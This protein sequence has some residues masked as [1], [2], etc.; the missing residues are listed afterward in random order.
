MNPPNMKVLVAPDK[1]K[2]SLDAPAAARAL[3][4]GMRQHRPDISFVE[5]PV[6]DGGD[7]FLNA[8]DGYG[9]R[10]QSVAV[11]GPLREQVIAEFGV[12]GNSAVVEMATSSGLKTVAGRVLNPMAAT[13]Y[14]VGELL[15]AARESGATKIVVGVGGSATTDGGAGMLV[16]LGARLLDADG[17]VLPDCGPAELR[18]VARVDL[19]GLR[20]DLASVR[21]LVA[22][23]VDSPLTGPTGAARVFAPQKGA[24]PQEVDV[25]ERALQ[26]WAD[27]LELATGRSSRDIP[28]VGAGG[29]V[30][31]A[32]ANVFQASLSPGIEVLL[33]LSGFD[34][35]LSQASLVITGEGQLDTQSLMGKA[36]LGVLR[37]ARR[38]RVPT[39]AVVGANLLSP[40]QSEAAGF[41]A[42]YSVTDLEPDL[43]TAMR[44]ADQLL[45]KLGS[46]VAH[47]HIC[48]RGQPRGVDNDQ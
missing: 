43:D 44:T 24:S 30:P 7:G 41:T 42:V 13:S 45:T 23:D 39:I 2:G 38:H 22:C 47:I 33:S 17:Q 18:R 15:V 34:G 19:S 14:G 37:A 27:V 32:L 46:Q 40:A 5:H 8:L 1:F 48:G 28:G 25:L 12:C 6:A 3:A 36:P 35:L 31:F 9:F 20:T 11:T 21:M 29:G 10:S 16:A 26:H 4:D